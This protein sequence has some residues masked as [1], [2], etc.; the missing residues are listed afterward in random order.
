[1]QEA[2][3]AQGMPRGRVVLPALLFVVAAIVAAAH[4]RVLS[5][6]AISLDDDLYLF[7]NPLLQQPGWSSA[8]LVFREV[9]G[10][11]TVEGYYEPLTLLSLMVDVARGGTADNLRPFH[12][13]NLILHLLNTMLIIVFLSMLFRQAWAAAMVGLLFGVHPLTV[14]PVA[15]VWERKTLLATFFAL[16]CLVLYVR[17]TR[18]PTWAV[19]GALLAV[20]VLAL[21]AKPTATPLPVLLLLLDFWPLRRLSWRAV[22]EKA[23]LFAIAAVSA[24]VTVVST[25]RSANVTLPTQY[26]ALQIPL[27]MG[28]LMAFYLGK[29]V[30]PAR[31]SSV[32]VLPEP[33]ALSQPLVLLG[34]AVTCT[35]LA[36]LAISLRRTRA[37]ATGGLFFFAAILPTLGVI[38]YSWVSASDKYVYFPLLGVLLPLAWL[39]GRWW[40]GD[41]AAPIGPRRRFGAVATVAILASVEMVATGRYLLLW[42][43]TETLC[44]HMLALAPQS[45]VVY[46]HLGVALARQGRTGEAIQCFREAIR[47][48][49]RFADAPYNMALQMLKQGKSAEAI[50]PLRTALALKRLFP[51]AHNNLG[52]ALAQQGQIDAAIEQFREAIRIRPRLAEAHSN[53]ALALVKRGNLDEA[54]AHY[55]EALRLSPGHALPHKNL[56]IALLRMRRID[57]AI[58]EYREALRIAPGDA[59]GHCDLGDLYI[60][61]GRPAEA[62]REYR[63]ALRSNPQHPRARQRLD[64][65]SAGRSDSRPS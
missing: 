8:V 49:P 12:V 47:V 16:W 14:E 64:A 21:L 46:T 7:Q 23:P 55:R 53:L 39:L 4:W 27:K 20:F 57:E 41:E 45:A 9:L 13:T 63:E 36:L 52:I 62:A 2:G 1:M 19:Y 6:G 58:R 18:R 33:L 5:A 42:R 50:A 59:D 25:S 40:Q 29:I 32:Y 24:V 15:W 44:R 54:V 37:L 38:R 26:S 3:A 28:Y 10:S 43:E 17:Y 31:L 22:W 35:V 61:R 48:E 51:E 11:S 65:L 56:G 34:V 60:G 30:W